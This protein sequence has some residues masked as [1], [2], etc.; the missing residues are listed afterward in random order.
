MTTLTVGRHVVFYSTRVAPR[1]DAGEAVDAARVLA[2][3][4]F[5]ELVD[6]IV[7]STRYSRRQAFLALVNT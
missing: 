6:M 1:L 4:I 3:T 7:H 2:T 5:T